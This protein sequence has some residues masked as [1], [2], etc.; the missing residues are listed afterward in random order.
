M[1]KKRYSRKRSYSKSRRASGKYGRSRK[2][3]FNRRVR[4][5]VLKTSET[6][7]RLGAVENL[8]LYHDRG[9][10]VAGPTATTQGAAIW[11][12]WFSISRG[13]APG[14]RIGDEVYPVGMSLR[15]CYWCA[16]D[17]QAQFV[18]IIVASVP[19]VNTYPGG[20]GQMVSDQGSYD[21]MDAGGSNDTV[22]GII[23]SSDSGIKVLYDR[24]WT[25][26]AK[27]KTEDADELGDNRFF[28]KIW[29]KA[30]R[31]SKLTWQQDGYLKNNP[32]GVWVIPYDD[33]NTLRTDILGRCSFTY[34][35]YFK[36]P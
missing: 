14:N 32:I 30:K 24:M 11:N 4:K 34:K 22:T 19:R 20:G 25:G 7:Y 26:T 8:A 33:Y 9:D 27:G 3:T 5:A 31:G 2:A 15:L 18:R 29:I 13:T 21:L 35:L 23:K 17:R 6:K 28:K 36:D 10:V 12:P 16:A 1:Y